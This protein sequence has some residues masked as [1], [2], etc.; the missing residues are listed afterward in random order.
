MNVQQDH[1]VCLFALLMLLEN[2]HRCVWIVPSCSVCSVSKRSKSNFLFFFYSIEASDSIKTTIKLEKTQSERLREKKIQ[3]NISERTIHPDA[4]DRVLKCHQH[5][6]KLIWLLTF[7]YFRTYPFSLCV[8]FIS[9]V[10]VGEPCLSSFLFSLS[11]FMIMTKA[12]LVY[13]M[14]LF[15]FI[16]AH[17]FDR[18]NC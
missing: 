2:F 16:A 10:A 4:P 18:Q 5:Q 15:D 1:C 13:L 12:C 11:F 3:E 17:K 14:R 9:R 7:V 8:P 6:Q